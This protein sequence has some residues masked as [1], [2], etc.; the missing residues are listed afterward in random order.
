[1]IQRICKACGGSFT[2]E[3][4]HQVYCSLRCRDAGR[5]E[6]RQKWVTRN[7]DYYQELKRRKAVD[8]ETERQA[9]AED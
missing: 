2:A 9:A 8:G 6:N 1:M 7:P 5:I 4:P 3:Y